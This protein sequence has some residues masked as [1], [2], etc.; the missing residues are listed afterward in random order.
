MNHLGLVTITN[1][2]NYY[3]I[4][5]HI[6]TKTLTKENIANINDQ[7]ALFQWIMLSVSDYFLDLSTTIQ[8]KIHIAT[9]KR[10]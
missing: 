5:T 9:I 3:I 1:L 6:T 10:K 4:I 2:I 7:F 8:H